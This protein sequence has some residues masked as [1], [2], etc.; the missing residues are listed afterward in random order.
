MF[1]SVLFSF[2]FLMCVL[3]LGVLKLGGHRGRSR[4]ALR[5]LLAAGGTELSSHFGSSPK[6]GGIG[7]KSARLGKNKPNFARDRPTT[8]QCGA[9]GPRSRGQ[10]LA[11]LSQLLANLD[12]TLLRSVWTTPELSKSCPE[13]LAKVW[14]KWAKLWPKLGDR[15]TPILADWPISTKHWRS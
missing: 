2:E 10:T 3:F 15:K 13:H 8:I 5:A 14:S 7:L 6:L 1:D 11:S 4:H 9:F 12:Q